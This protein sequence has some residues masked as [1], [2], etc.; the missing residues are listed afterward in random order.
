MSSCPDP[1]ESPEPPPS[2]TGGIKQSNLSRAWEMFGRICDKL[3]LNFPPEKLPPGMSVEMKAELIGQEHRLLHIIRNALIYRSFPL[4]DPRRR[5]AFNAGLWRLVSSPGVQTTGVAVGGTFLTLAT[6]WVACVQ[7][8]I[9]REQTRLLQAQKESAD[10]QALLQVET[11]EAGRTAEL[12]TELRGLIDKMTPGSGLPGRE[13]QKRIAGLC[14]VLRAYRYID[15]KD[16]KATPSRNPLSRERGDLFQA[17]IGIRGAGRIEENADIPFYAY[18]QFDRADLAWAE[19]PNT[20][21]RS[22]YLRGAFF[23]QAK[24]AGSKFDYAEAI[25]AE[26]IGAMLTDEVGPNLRQQ[27]AEKS[28][29]TP[30]E[31]SPSMRNPHVTFKKA[32]L[33]G[34]SF[35]KS[36]AKGVD[37]SEAKVI[38]ANFSE[39]W[40][41]EAVF[42]KA[43]LREAIFTKAWLPEASAF[44]GADLTGANFWEAR[45]ADRRWI[46]ELSNQASHHLHQEAWRVIPLR[47]DEIDQVLKEYRW[48]VVPRAGVQDPI[49]AT[50]PREEPLQPRLP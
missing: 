5:E 9:A 3:G 2:A 49:A 48:K 34:A 20:D 10:E 23:F 26:F 50:I 6:L 33:T 17:C 24:L 7:M 12:R 36:D 31:K 11:A 4:D 40:L 1:A 15:W 38:G 28:G 42:S 16:G 37:F 39:S 47:D 18:F 32:N 30:P 13:T 29:Q 43:W 27:M 44:L 14:R 41:R 19:L 35:G 21:G 45:V 25:D 22:C 46:W 8:D